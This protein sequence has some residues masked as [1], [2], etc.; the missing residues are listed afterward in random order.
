VSE[1]EFEPVPGLPERLP[2]GERILWQGSPDP[3]A[4]ALQAFHIRKVAVYFA[5]LMAGSF[6]AGIIDGEAAAAASLSALGLV[7]VAAAGLGLIALLAWL[8]ARATIYT[9]TN[10]R[11]VLRFGVA[12]PM[13]LNVPFTV[14]ES[15]ALRIHP[16]GSGDLP[17]ALADGQRIAWL[18]NWPYVRGGRRSQ[19][20][21]RAV[22]EAARV[23]TL[24]GEALAR[25]SGGSATVETAI[26]GATAAPQRQAPPHVA[27]PA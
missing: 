11:V 20:M 14:I 16:G 26:R 7:P 25:H 17:L 24:L 4:L 19:P 3:K 9:I 21:L 1:H 8:T 22:P 12:L 18:V 23:A 10:R 27:A 6:A 13:A 5:I 2:E 15:A